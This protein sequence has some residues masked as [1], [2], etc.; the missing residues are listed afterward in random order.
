MCCDDQLYVQLHY[1]VILL[2]LLYQCECVA[3]LALLNLSLVT[4]HL[5]LDF[6]QTQEKK[7]FFTQLQTNYQP[8]SHGK[9]TLL[10]K[11]LN[12]YFLFI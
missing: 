12:R 7:T 9:I 4:Q 2:H 5:D 3:L 11:S 1:L 10:N 6:Q 8:F